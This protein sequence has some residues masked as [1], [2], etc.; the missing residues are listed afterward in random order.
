[1]SAKRKMSVYTVAELV[2][3]L[4]RMTVRRQN[5]LNLELLELRDTLA[6]QVGM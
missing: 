6:H 3:Q 5:L 1:M 2:S 4:G